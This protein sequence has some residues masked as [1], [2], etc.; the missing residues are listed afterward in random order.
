MTEA[1]YLGAVT[2]YEVVL[3][4]GT[5]LAVMEANVL[6]IGDRLRLAPG[7]KI[8]AVWPRDA[9]AVLQTTKTGEG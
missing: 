4:D 8:L 7:E 9:A 1:S 5:G 2:R 6:P 3:L